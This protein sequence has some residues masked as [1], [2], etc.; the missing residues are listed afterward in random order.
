MSDADVLTIDDFGPLPVRRANSVEELCQLVREVR[1]ENQ[2]IYPFGGR[3]TLDYGFPPSRPGIALDMRALD[4][5]V[6]YPASDMTVT[7]QAGITILRLQQLL[8]AENQRLPIDVPRAA[9]ATLGGIVATNTSGP[10]RYGF[11]AL[12]D[13][14]IGIRVINDSG[15]ETKAGG[16]VVKNVA[17]Y[18][19]CKLHIGALGTLGVISELTLKVRP[20]PEQR[21][22]L[23][24]PCETADTTSL[25]GRLHESAT[26]PVCVDLLNQRMA[27]VIEQQ[28]G[29]RMPSTAWVAAVGLE[30][31]GAALQWQ[32]QQLLREMPH[33]RGLDVRVGLAADGLWAALVEGAGPMT[34]TLSITANVVPSAT[35]GFCGRLQA[36]FPNLALHAHAGNGV[37][38]IHLFEPLD[39]QQARVMLGQAMEWCGT[40][41]NVVVQRCPTPWKAILPLWGKPRSDEWLM[42]KIKTAFDPSN[43]FNPGRFLGRM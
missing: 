14:V 43:T 3:T 6:D 29:I 23:I 33:A 38:H 2:A 5:V 12:R 34:P 4:R 26:R 15:C 40:H 39:L 42:R 17:G 7:V 31:N 1:E 21:A 18:D 32:I 27:R 41:G 22:L 19:L 24:V 20:M 13:Y 30:D 36:A 37:V 10:R 16:R 11:G 35:A 8:A 28:T 9:G 25:L